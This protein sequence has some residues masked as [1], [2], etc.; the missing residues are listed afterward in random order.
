MQF[1]VE[2]KSWNVA[3]AIQFN[4]GCEA[5]LKDI[6]KVREELN[7]PELN[8]QLFA[9]AASAKRENPTIDIDESLARELGVFSDKNTHTVKVY[10]GS[11]NQFT[12][13]APNVVKD[14]ENGCIRYIGWMIELNENA[15]IDAWIE[16]GHP[17]EWIMCE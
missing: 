15:V 6:D 13:L 11:L 9:S 3:H 1:T 5:G 16:A 2:F 7:I 8:V 10:M 12:Y 4:W 14:P 17:D